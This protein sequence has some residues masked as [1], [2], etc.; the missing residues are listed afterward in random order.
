MGGEDRTLLVCVDDGYAQTKLYGDGPDGKP[1]KFI[2]RS[3]VR[4]GRYG[5]GTLSGAGGIG[6]YETEEGD[7]FTVSEDIE[8][9]N[10]QFDGFHTSTMNRVLVTHALMSAGY[11]GQPVALWTGLPVAD[12]F[13]DDEKDLEKIGAKRANLVKGVANTASQK[14][15]PAVRSVDVGCQ[16]VAA[17]MDY[18]LDDDLNERFDPTASSV[19]IIDVGGRTTDI[20]VVINGAGIDHGRSGT[21]NIGV[22]DVYTALSK[23][24]RQ[25]FKTR[26]KFPLAML[27]QAVRTG[28]LSL[29][30]QEH[31]V[32][33]L[34]QDIL[35][36]IEGKIAR[37]VQRKLGSGSTLK[38]ICF[39]GGGGA[40]FKDIGA[41]FPNGVVLDD[42][43][44]ANARGLWKYARY[45]AAG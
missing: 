4:P 24:I 37:E 44:F 22:L 32:A 39:V 33:D 26:D 21:E 35:K 10:T 36:E 42:P 17:Y 25:R 43:E 9:E 6:S 20:C 15:V 2:M 11:G 19:A 12:Y 30:A 41:H 1:V 45:F 31:D 38:A 7:Q 8:A 13:F 23:S 29:W 40:L 18:L 5:L 34:V 14:P 3:S 27:D 16:A 28:R